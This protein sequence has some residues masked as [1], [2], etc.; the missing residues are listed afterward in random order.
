MD[1]QTTDL[2][3]TASILDEEENQPTKPA[4][5]AESAKQELL[6]PEPDPVS[7]E[8]PTLRGHSPAPNRATSLRNNSIAPTQSLRN[9]SVAPTQNLRSFDIARPID[10]EAMAL[11]A[12]RRSK[13]SFGRG[14]D[15]GMD[16]LRASVPAVTSIA[17]GIVGDEE[18]AM[19]DAQRAAEI[20]ERGATLGPQ[21][22]AQDVMAGE[23]S[24]GSYVAGL[25][26]S[27]APVIGS[28]LVSGGLGGVAGRA[29]GATALRHVTTTAARRKAISTARSRVAAQAAAGTPVTQSSKQLA[30]KALLAPAVRRGQGAGAY[31]AGFGLQSG[32]A[33]DIL[34]DTESGASMRER[35][36][37]ALGGA[38]GTAAF[39]ALPI[40]QVFERLGLG[41]IARTGVLREVSRNNLKNTVQGFASQ[42]VIEGGTEVAQSVAMKAAHKLVNDNIELLSDEALL[43][44]MEEGIAGAI[45]GGTVGAASSIRIPNYGEAQTAVQEKIAQSNLDKAKRGAAENGTAVEG[46][47]A[48][49]MDRVQTI[50]LGKGVMESI[51]APIE[52]GDL[53]S[54]MEVGSALRA[55]LDPSANGDEVLDIDGQQM[56]RAEAGAELLA[57]KYGVDINSD[58][59]LGAAREV[60]AAGEEIRIDQIQAVLEDRQRVEE[61]ESTVPATPEERT[62]LEEELEIRQ[63][64]LRQFQTDLAGRDDTDAETDTET[65][66]ALNEE[67]LLSP[68]GDALEVNEPIIRPA[69]TSVNRD[70][71]VLVSDTDLVAAIK[72]TPTLG[73]MFLTD[74]T[75]GVRDTDPTTRAQVL[76]DQLNNETGSSGQ[77]TTVPAGDATV[78]LLRLQAGLEDSNTA[79]NNENI[80]QQVIDEA[81]RVVASNNPRRFQGD[82]APKFEGDA[83]TVENYNEAVRVLNQFDTVVEEQTPG[84]ALGR[85]AQQLTRGEIRQR[86]IVNPDPD[87]EAVAAQDS[88]KLAV[89][90]AN[91]NPAVVDLVALTQAMISRVEKAGRGGTNAERAAR[92]EAAEAGVSGGV[93][94]QNI[95]RAISAGLAEIFTRNG[96]APAGADAAT[97]DALA[98]E[99]AAVAARLDGLTSESSTSIG[100]VEALESQLAEIDAR[101]AAVPTIADIID[102]NA[103]VFRTSTGQRTS[104]GGAARTQSQ[105]KSARGLI[106]DIRS[107]TNPAELQVR[108]QQILDKLEEAK[109]SPKIMR[110]KGPALRQALALVDRRLDAVDALSK[111]LRAVVGGANAKDLQK[112]SEL[113]IQRITGGVHEDFNSLAN[114]V[115]G[116]PDSKIKEIHQARAALTA[117]ERTQE[118]PEPP[119]A[120]QAAAKEADAEPFERTEFEGGWAE[121]FTAKGRS[122]L[123]TM[124]GVAIRKHAVRSDRQKRERMTASADW[125][126][127]PETVAN[128]TATI[129]E[130]VS[131][132]VNEFGIPAP[133][134]IITSDLPAGTMGMYHAADN[135][136]E[137][138]AGPFQRFESMPVKMLTTLTHE[139]S[140]ALETHVILDA[141]DTELNALAG[142]YQKWLANAK[143]R[144]DN[145]DDRQQ[146]LLKLLNEKRGQIAAA[147]EKIDPAKLRESY[148]LDPREWFADNAARMIVEESF[149]P[150]DS[151]VG[152]KVFERMAA[153]LKRLY[154]RLLGRREIKSDDTPALKALLVDRKRTTGE[155]IDPPIKQEPV[156][157][158]VLKARLEALDAEERAAIK[159]RGQVMRLESEFKKQAEAGLNPERL[160]LDRLR[161][162]VNMLSLYQQLRNQRRAEERAS[163]QDAAQ[164]MGEMLREIAEVAARDKADEQFVELDKFTNPEDYYA[165]ETGEVPPW[166]T[167]PFDIDRIQKELPSKK[168][169]GI[170]ERQIKDSLE[171]DSI[172]VNDVRIIPWTEAVARFDNARLLKNEAALKNV[173]S[174]SFI[175]NG[176]VFV[177]INEA[178]AETK[179]ARED[180]ISRETALI[181]L[182][183]LGEKQLDALA[184]KINV[185][186]ALVKEAVQT[187]TDPSSSLN[188]NHRA[189]L[190]DV[191]R[192]ISDKRYDENLF[193]VTKIEP[194]LDAISKAFK[195][196]PSIDATLPDDA[197]PDDVRNANRAVAKPWTI[198]GFEAAKRFAMARLTAQERGVLARA[199]LNERVRTQMIE[200]LESNNTRPEQF[201]DTEEDLLGLG[202]AMQ[203]AGLLDLG[204]TAIKPVQKIS[205]AAHRLVGAVRRSD[206]VEQIMKAISD[207]SL[208][209]RHSLLDEAPADSNLRKQRY[210]L[211]IAHVH[212]LNYILNGDSVALEDA[213]AVIEN[214]STFDDLSAPERTALIQDIEAA[215]FTDSYMGKLLDAGNDFLINPDKQ[216]VLETKKSDLNAAQEAAHAVANFIERLR[217]LFNV[218]VGES[219]RARFSNNAAIMGL[220]NRVYTD[221]TSKGYGE[222]LFARKM[223]RSAEFH[224]TFHDAV[225]NLTDEQQTALRDLMLGRSKTD[226]QVVLQARRKIKKLMQSMR[227][228]GRDAGLEIGNRGAN[229]VPWVF[230]PI[231]VAENADALIDNWMQD[232]FADDWTRLARERNW[233]GKKET[234]SVEQRHRFI[235]TIV[236][237]IA[238]ENGGFVDNVDVASVETQPHVSA[239]FTRDLGF[240]ETKGNEEAKAML[241]E[242]FSDNIGTTMFTY[243]DQMVK[244]AEYARTFGADGRRFASMKRRAQ[245]LGASHRDLQ[246][247][248]QIAASALGRIGLEVSPF[249][250]LVLSPLEKTVMT[251]IMDGDR[252]FRT[253]KAALEAKQSGNYTGQ[254]RKHEDGGFYIDR[255]ITNDPARFRRA[256]SAVVVYQNMILL[257]LAA[258]TNVA[259]AA[260]LLFR[261]GDVATAFEGYATAM[262][263]TVRSLKGQELSDVRKLGEEL[264]IVESSVTSEILGQF[265]G[266][267]M[268]SGKARRVNDWFFRVNGMEHLTRTLR[269]S[270][271]VSGRRYIY[272][273]AKAAAQNDRKATEQL[274]L[275]GI[276]AED[277]EFDEDNIKLLSAAE[278]AELLEPYDISVSA[279]REQVLDD[280][281]IERTTGKERRRQEALREVARDDRVKQALNRMV[282][283]SV[284]RPNPN[285]RPTWMNDPNWQIFS[286]LKGFYFTYHEQILRRAYTRASQGDFTPALYMMS[287]VPIMLATD[288]LRDVL[289]SGPDD[290]DWELSFGERLDDAVRRSGIYGSIGLL[291]DLVESRQYGGTIMSD[292]LGPTADHFEKLVK[293]ASGRGSLSTAFDR[294]MPFSQ[295]FPDVPATALSW[296]DYVAP[297]DLGIDTP[298]TD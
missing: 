285:Q 82:R 262:R 51:D 47:A 173:A 126:L 2:R 131:E 256:Q 167:E 164:I 48:E 41:S 57:R 284:L 283:E 148:I 95:G 253:S 157:D 88:S 142:E 290:D 143:E 147:S 79:V 268:M 130:L 30:R 240:I 166:V 286:H 170:E 292:V 8:P 114:A 261:T 134:V 22:S 137:L 266:G 14:L 112:R 223:R 187:R 53:D 196:M 65:D 83:P 248:D 210:A 124:R 64:R 267:N 165:A 216:F 245:S 194:D 168:Q 115:M 35:A 208:D 180:L 60:L 123:K 199:M 66:A 183:L 52:D 76:A 296:A 151:A 102:T 90:D 252:P 282:N 81:K 54:A 198:E 37:A 27:Q 32:E 40:M 213:G 75:P 190:R 156:E 218:W 141:S 140:H 228:Y 46:T 149:K 160:M 293:A 43:Q 105:R 176:N 232:D 207:R 16:T 63:Q 191:Q 254:V 247:M 96:Y 139:L 100:E 129:E 77:F 138:N 233:I 291:P 158:P 108:K 234:L 128:I 78:R 235:R 271:L 33:V 91:G 84:A 125:D 195:P 42:A 135:A 136:I 193:S 279:A 288:L 297:G 184:K 15:Q 118:A 153:L 56:T 110:D 243:I 217:P 13:S 236:N 1:R 214:N 86:N 93:S 120:D 263:E 92:G 24:V 289:T 72:G 106:E 172:E 116:W 98:D 209:G 146:E 111:Q 269:L 25:L 230:D 145:A 109:S 272:N 117:P 250:K 99:R 201:L 44:Y 39:E 159:L 215:V 185:P 59:L 200:Y 58:A 224:G 61:I 171:I 6:A 177:W 251:P 274:S 94:T 169:I 178:A 38:A 11:N 237:G 197:T 226:D 205:E 229:Y 3:G 45:V 49:R 280:Q 276:T 29:A 212:E 23:A 70:N 74:R 287:Y 202:I 260:G 104:L 50:Y 246:L 31:A 192:K 221:V 7:K 219:M 36:A 241:G 97:L 162:S 26:G 4:S 150:T 281:A 5:V 85:D 186:V 278:V 152:L 133:E 258:L 101:I 242:M 18:G 154:A 89:V 9:L 294:S 19:R 113:M 174:Y 275:L 265:Y 28:M 182:N 103:T 87:A 175:E 68:T 277:V 132:Y 181:K 17:R 21:I 227:T 244:R 238:T 144:L 239:M 107:I 161:A 211:N 20:Q 121:W 257:P 231:K 62:A 295:V 189:E 203:R 69:L 179:L 220:L 122:A 10:R 188:L 119:I 71:G 204:T 264:G 206:Q 80:R 163:N 255:A 127:P 222:A 259:D 73:R 273:Q 225:R 298:F 155:P 34:L 55:L 270:A 12:R 249:W 67:A